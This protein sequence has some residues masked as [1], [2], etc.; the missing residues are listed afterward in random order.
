MSCHVTSHRIASHRVTRPR[1]NFIFVEIS[2]C[3]QPFA[4]TRHR[5]SKSRV[6]CCIKSWSSIMHSTFRSSPLQ[7]TVAVMFARVL[8][9][10]ILRNAL[11]NSSLLLNL[12]SVVLTFMLVGFAVQM[13]WIMFVENWIFCPSPTP[14]LKVV[15]S[16][17]FR[18]RYFLY[19]RSNSMFDYYLSLF[20]L[21]NSSSNRR[22][23]M[24]EEFEAQLLK[25][26]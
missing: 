10:I 3:V 25:F 12:F 7:S 5:Q 21:T 4:V 13:G 24:S 9:H 11:D 20:S 8:S 14:R 26:F 19:M 23:K 1:A 18:R 6:R 15:R 22:L 17:S 2:N 16:V